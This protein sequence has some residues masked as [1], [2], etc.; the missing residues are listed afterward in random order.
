MGK[1]TL[2]NRLAGTRRS[3]TAPTPGVTRD[4]V[5]LHDR[6]GGFWILDTG[7]QGG[8]GEM[9]GRV[10]DA[11]RRAQE[12]A[13]LC[14]LVLDAHRPPSA[15]DRAV[16]DALLA[17]GEPFLTVVNKADHDAAV[18]DAWNRVASLPVEP[19]MVSAEAVRGID[20]LRE[21]IAELLP[22]GDP[23]DP[24][25]WPLVGLFGRPG[26]G[27]ST[28]FNAILG[29]T[30]ALVGEDGPTTRDSVEALW[31]PPGLRLLDT[32]GLPRRRG[33]GRLAAYARRRTLGALAVVDAAFLLVDP[34]EGATH[35][36]RSI[37]GRLLEEGASVAMLS[38]KADLG[39]EPAA[40][41][42]FA[43]HVP[44]RP[45]S[46]LTGEGV[47]ALAPLALDLLERRRTTVPTAGLVACLRDA[48][49][50]WP[51]SG[52]RRANLLY[53]SQTGVEPPTFLVFVDEPR[54]IDEAHVRTLETGLRAA[55]DL[56]GVP[57][58]FSFRGRREGKV[59]PR[60]SRSQ[61]TSK[62]SPTWT[63]T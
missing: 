23:E 53:A 50:A 18:A 25:D 37:L 19:L 62:E 27:K 46:G 36:D 14:V 57:L 1:S 60:R 56:A 39:H 47:A 38:G 51:K 4:A 24:R 3:I 7:G 16:L 41:P 44:V 21:A 12:G 26:V 20:E 22:V 5:L 34:I 49:E 52:R 35:Q 58:R 45:V 29:E 11:A 17:A 59:P 61:S 6:E 33:K 31:G 28:L 15:E 40:A 42:A 8:Q 48:A 32:G 9:A 10:A 43:D 55:A 2:A 13:D 63:T 30:V 54:R